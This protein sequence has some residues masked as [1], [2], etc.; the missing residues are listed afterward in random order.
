MNKELFCINYFVVVRILFGCIFLNV[1]ECL[2]FMFRLNFKGIVLF[3]FKSRGNFLIV[4]V[5]LVGTFIIFF[6]IFIWLL[7]G[8]FRNCI[9]GILGVISFF[10]R[11]VMFNLGGFE[12]NFKLFINE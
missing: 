9:N 6:V 8:F 1:I 7:R 12:G 5:I 10:L 3:L 11:G 2:K 4:E